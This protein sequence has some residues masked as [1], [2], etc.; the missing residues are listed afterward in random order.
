VYY[1]VTSLIVTY[2]Y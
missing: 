2:I 1:D